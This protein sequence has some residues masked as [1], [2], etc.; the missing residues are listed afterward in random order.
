MRQRAGWIGLVLVVVAAGG[1]LALRHFAG[2]E[3]TDDAQID[4]HIV[5]VSPRVEAPSRR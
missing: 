5:P 4:G 3:S 2:R 1:L